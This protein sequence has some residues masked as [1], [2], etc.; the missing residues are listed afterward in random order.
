MDITKVSE[1]FNASAL[2]IN[3]A[4]EP[5][6]GFSIAQIMGFEKIATV[7]T[8]EE[9]DAEKV[10]STYDAHILPCIGAGF[11]A[12]PLPRSATI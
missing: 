5:R 10:S 4:T 9:E 3:F 8:E 12:S 6:I 1:S 7:P 11:R 2:M